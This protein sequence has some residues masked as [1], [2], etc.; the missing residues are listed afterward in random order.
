MAFRMNQKV[1]I[2]A[3][4]STDGIPQMGVVVGIVKKPDA[5]Y[6]SYNTFKQY[7]ANLNDIEYTVAYERKVSGTMRI[8]TEK[9]YEKDLAKW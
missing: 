4:N 1:H 6:L 5:Y 7:I 2:K 9:Y 8:L 3:I